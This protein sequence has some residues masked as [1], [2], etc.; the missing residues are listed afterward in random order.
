MATVDAPS[1]PRLAISATHVLIAAAHDHVVQHKSSI[2]SA[3]NCR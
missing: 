3:A 2:S 1:V